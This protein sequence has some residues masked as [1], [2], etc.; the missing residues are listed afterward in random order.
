MLQLCFDF[1]LNLFRGAL[2]LNH[3]K[4]ADFDLICK[5]MLR[6]D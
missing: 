6:R 3:L 5:S 2:D 4:L 1:D